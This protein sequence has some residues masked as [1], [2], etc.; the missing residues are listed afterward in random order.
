MIQ[1]C[2]IYSRNTAAEGDIADGQL[3]QPAK[4]L[5]GASSRWQ[6]NSINKATNSVGPVKKRTGVRI[7]FHQSTLKYK[8]LFNI[9]M[10]EAG[11]NA[12][13]TCN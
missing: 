1:I 10:P 4:F 8:V 6:M 12:S 5:F 7:L 9:F 3:R 2:S 11:V 13:F